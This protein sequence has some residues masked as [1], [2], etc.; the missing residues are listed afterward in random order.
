MNRGVWQA[1]FHRFTQESNTTE[2]TAHT[3][4]INRYTSLYTK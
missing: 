4:G 1:A 2:A 3:R